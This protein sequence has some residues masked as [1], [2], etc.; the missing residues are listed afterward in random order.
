[1]FFEPDSFAGD[2]KNHNI[3][4]YILVFNVSQQNI[5]LTCEHVFKY[6][7]IHTLFSSIFNQM[8]KIYRGEWMT[9]FYN[10]G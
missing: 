8:Y 6:S 9:I 7:L 3:Y 2:L 1:M 5:S 10:E 4:F